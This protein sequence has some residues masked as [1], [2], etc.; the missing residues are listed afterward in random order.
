MDET[1]R[2]NIPKSDEGGASQ[3]TFHIG[4]DGG[5]KGAIVVLDNEGNIVQKWIMPMIKGKKPEY[6]IVG[7]SCIFDSLKKDNSLDLMKVILEQPLIL[8]INGRIG[9]ASTHFC[10]GIFQ[11]ILTAMNISYEVVRAKDWQKV[12]LRG[13]NLKDTKQASIM[14]CKRKYPKVDFRATERSKKDSDGICDA[15]CMA[16]YSFLISRK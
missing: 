3:M 4:I 5:K 11:G 12:V 16:Y 15:T 2:K 7:I 8:P 13:L 1:Q 10:Y 6:D 9:V 14:W